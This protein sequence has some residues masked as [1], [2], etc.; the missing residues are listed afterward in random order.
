[1]LGIAPLVHE[2]PC[3]TGIIYVID[4]GFCKQKSYNP[5]TGVDCMQSRTR[6]G[7]PRSQAWSRLS[8][9][10]SRAPLRSSVLVAL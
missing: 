4:C 3:G 10:P 7:S 8:L 5:R 9:R 1:M 2:W 6:R